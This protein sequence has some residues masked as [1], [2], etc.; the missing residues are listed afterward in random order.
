MRP[1]HDPFLKLFYR[2]AARDA[3]TLFFPELAAHIDW[4]SLQWIEK[5]VP[6]LSEPPRS[7]VADLVGLTRDVEGR[8]LEVL[9]HP[10]IQMRTA[11]DMGWR[12]LQYNAGLTLQQASAG[13]RVLTIVFYHCRGAG[14]V[15]EERHRLEFYGHSVLEAGYWSVGLG[16][17]DADQYVE[18]ENP[19]AWALASWM[20]QRRAG[21]V[22]LRLRLLGK[23]LRFVRDE[24]Y[25]RLLLDAVRTYFRLSGRE[26]AE[27]EQLLQS[28]MYGE[29]N[30][31]LQTELGRL[32][33]AAERKALHNAI[34]TVLRSRFTAVPERLM[35][36]IGR[37]QDV[38]AL[39][40]LIGRAA[41]VSSLEEFESLLELS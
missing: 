24:P 32:E 31:M 29:V 25:R 9:L 41:V 23:I 17:L 12:V 5:E 26:A 6:I 40:E 8:Y 39:E 16:D 22:E 37:V 1:R 18:S 34:V 7:I 4:Q 19:A 30:E 13:A 20:R 14:G 35:A 38:A 11:A 36:R 27:E 21:R 33:D 15:R 28:Q 2:A 10:E 3:V